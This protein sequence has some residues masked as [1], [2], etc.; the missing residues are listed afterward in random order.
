MTNPVKSVRN[1]VYSPL[2]QAGE[3]SGERASML[4]NAK[5]LRTNQTEAGQR[6]WYHLRAH[7]FLGLKFKR[8]KPVGRYIVDFICMEHRLIIELDGGQH[9]EHATRDQQWDGWLR[10]QG[11]KVLRFWNNEVMQ[12]TESVLEQIRN[13]VTLSPCPSPAKT[14]SPQSYTREE[15]A[16]GY[17]PA[18]QRPFRSPASG[19]GGEREKQYS[20][21]GRGD[22]PEAAT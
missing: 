2:P 8:Q 16:G 12:Q 17:P 4:T 6:L 3:G 20:S 18:S 5:S 19:R 11:Y 22:R 1:T 21:S 10:D 14:P 15:Y 13:V 9:A 7:R